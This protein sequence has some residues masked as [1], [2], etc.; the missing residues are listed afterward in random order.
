LVSLP[1]VG[2]INYALDHIC[3]ANFVIFRIYSA[4]IPAKAGIYPDGPTV[5]P[6]TAGIR[7]G[8]GQSSLPDGF[9]LS[10]E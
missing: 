8:D 6:K 9:L 2:E 1:L 4:V 7:P 3:Q 10:Q 5:A